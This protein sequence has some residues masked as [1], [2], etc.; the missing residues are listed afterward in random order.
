MSISSGG[1]AGMDVDDET[2][3]LIFERAIRTETVFAKSQQLAVSFYSNLPMEVK[4]ILKNSGEPLPYSVA[5]WN[6]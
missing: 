6:Y 5:G 2:T 3:S 4:Q 1:A